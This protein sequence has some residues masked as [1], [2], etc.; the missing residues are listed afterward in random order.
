MRINQIV[1][2]PMLIAKVYGS[3]TGMPKE[4]KYLVYASI[5]PSVAY[6]M[7]FT[8]LSYFLTAV[9]GVS[10]DFMG[11]VITSMGVSTFVASIF[12][13]IA[14]DVYG[15]KRLLVGGNVLASLIIIVF[16]LTTNPLLLLAAAIFEGISEAAILA[17]S[18][19]LLAEK[20]EDEK[21]TSVFSLYGFAQSI[22]FGIGSFAV[23]AV[24]LFELFGFTNRESHILLYILISISSLIS[25]FLMVKVKESKGL[26]KIRT[27]ILDLLPRKSKSILLKYVLTGAIIAFGAGMVVPL[28]TLWFNLRYG[29]SDTISAPILAVSSILIALA[30]LV[31]PLLAKRFGLIKAIVITQITSTIFMFATPFSPSYALAG[32]VYSTRALLMNMASPLSQSMIMGLVPEDERGT[33][34]GI[35]GALW[36]LPNALSTW[37]G[38]WLM[39]IGLLVEPFLMAGLFYIVSIMLFWY[40]FRKVNA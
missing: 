29:I 28:M 5:M 3:Y 4:V 21:R 7:L 31:A 14:A 6:G 18:S 1:G 19:A 23:P 37:I 13:G 10:A 40:F 24:V 9:Q 16:A 33:A 12:L 27:D 34:S 35:S 2:I 20:G 39:G 11:I 38:A 15:R 22:A 36:R 25:T 17:S 8:D 30:I 32:F 26:K